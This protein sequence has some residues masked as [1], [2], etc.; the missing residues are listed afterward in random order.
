MCAVSDPLVTSV[1]RYYA[2]VSPSAAT[3]DGLVVA[4]PSDIVSLGV[5]GLHPDSQHSTLSTADGFVTMWPA[6]Q[7]LAKLDALHADEQLLRQGWVTLVGTIPVDGEPVRIRQPIVSRP[8][9]IRG[10]SGIGRLAAGLTDLV[11]VDD[12]LL[13]SLGEFELTPLVIDPARRS[14]LLSTMEFGRGGLQNGEPSERFLRRFPA[15]TTWIHTVGAELGTPA[16]RVLPHT[17]DVQALIDSPGLVAVVEHTIYLGRRVS[18]LSQRTTLLNWSSRADLGSTALRHVVEAAPTSAGDGSDAGFPSA[19]AIESPLVLSASQRDVV[20]RARHAPVTVVS[21]APGSGKTHT[22]CAIAADAIAQGRSVLIATQSRYAAEVVTELLRRTPGPEPVR[23][24]DGAGMAAL[25][26]ELT[27]RQGHPLGTD[28]IHQL[29]MELE[30]SRTAVNGLRSSIAADLELLVGA[31]DAARWQDAL[32][33][34]TAT[35]P[36][37]FEPDSDLDAAH[38]ALASAR[39]SAERAAGG[40][41]FARWRA[42]RGRRTLDRLTGA[43]GR[44]D[45]TRLELAVSAARSRRAAATLAAR[46]GVALGPRWQRLVAAEEQLRAAVG[47]RVS[48]SPFEPGRLDGSARQ[49][50]GQLIAALRAGRGRRRELLGELRPGELTAAAPLWIGTLSEIEDVLPATA[51]LFD[52]VVLDEASQIEQTRA[53][54]ALLRGRRAVVVGDPYQLRHV[55]FRSDADVDDALARHGL[56]DRRGLLDT[57]RVSAFDLAASAAPIDQLRDHFRSVPHLIEFSIRRFYRDRIDV[58]TRHPSNETFDAIDVVRSAQGDELHDEVSTTVALVREL[59][60]RGERSVGVVSPFRAQADALESA[61][62]TSFTTDE[63]ERMSLR[64]GTVHAFQGGER[65]VVIAALG[66]RATDPAGRRRFAEDANLFNVMVTR[67]RRRMVVVTSLPL[68]DPGLVGEYLRHGEA[69]LPPVE[70]DGSTDGWAAELAAELRRNGAVVRTQYPVGPW[71]LDLVVGDGDRCRY[72][73]CAVDPAGPE[74][75]IERHLTL[76]RLGWQIVDAYP[77]AWD[78]DVVRAALDLR[79]AV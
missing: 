29:D 73:E 58:M 25:I 28:Q 78:G 35:A 51:G 72:L 36:L 63:I 46:G 27:D 18:T 42:R 48:A 4:E 9:R 70:P 24:G 55:S 44:T 15:L 75:H 76:M 53:A 5:S 56:S 64:V 23:F 52:V 16:I 7:R 65:D 6:L 47:R 59:L 69:A 14:V 62:V 31:A 20:R 79:D 68:D 45:I 1:L 71:R 41:V 30:L 39:R 10:R 50:L 40:G 11:G 61:L 3:A 77:S 33:D 66:L 74:A 19:A 57:R 12:L 34:L 38:A 13:S 2:D 49:A 17:S 26:D 43:T 8:V 37:L 21:G 60:E 22:V 54:P 67:A 32:V